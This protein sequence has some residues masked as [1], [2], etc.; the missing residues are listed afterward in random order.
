MFEFTIEKLK[1]LM[2]ERGLRQIDLADTLCISMSAIN[3]KMLGKTE[4]TLRE[5]KELS[6]LFNV[7]FIINGRE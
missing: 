6:K 3:N 7:E 4:F 2:A 5:I 1:G